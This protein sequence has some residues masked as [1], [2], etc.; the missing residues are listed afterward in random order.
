LR[1]TG[2][3]TS[4]R[5]AFES[6]TGAERKRKIALGYSDDLLL[7]QP[8]VMDLNMRAASA[9]VMV[10]RHLLQPFLRT[11]LPVTIAENFLTFNM[12]AV[13][14]ARSSNDSCDICQANP[15]SGFGDSS[16]PIGLSPEIAAALQGED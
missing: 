14:K 1:C 5:L 10:L 7:K 3:V 13:S 6:L 12:K 4:R 15:Q 16:G 8:A 11:P 9:G 2:L